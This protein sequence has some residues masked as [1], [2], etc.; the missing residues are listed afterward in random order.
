MKTTRV[1]PSG[2]LFTSIVVAQS[3]VKP[4]AGEHKKNSLKLV[5]HEV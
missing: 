4:V 5:A 2:L 1:A 3:S